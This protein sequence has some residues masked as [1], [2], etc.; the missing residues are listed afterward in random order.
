M[1]PISMCIVL[2]GEF[3]QVLSPGSEFFNI[4]Y[5]ACPDILKVPF[6]EQEG[7]A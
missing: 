4:P 3:L 1:A 2:S 6:N 5:W 7:K